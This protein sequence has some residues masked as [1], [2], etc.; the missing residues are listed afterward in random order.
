M[1]IIWAFVLLLPI[2]VCRPGMVNWDYATW[3]HQQQMLKPG[4]GGGFGLN[5]PFIPVP[6]HILPEKR[7]FYIDES[8][9]YYERHYNGSGDNAESRRS[10]C[11]AINALANRGYINRNGRN[12]TYSQLAHAVRRV[13]NFGDDN[14]CRVFLGSS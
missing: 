5:D 2:A 7:P 12:I 6:A 9:H 11:P 14:V 10:S 13:W 8:L 4:D 3:Y 1:K